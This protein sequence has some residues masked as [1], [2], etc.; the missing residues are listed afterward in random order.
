MR[1]MDRRRTPL[2]GRRLTYLAVGATRPESADWTPPPSGRLRFERTV[3]I[4]VGDACWQAASS[5]LFSWGVKTRS[6]FTVE[7]CTGDLR[8]RLGERFWLVARVGPVAVKEP[9]QVTAFVDQDDRRGFAYGTLAGH[10]VSGEEAF[11]VHRDADGAVFFSLR[12][13]TSPASGWWRVAFPAVL[14]AQRV[15]RRRYLRALP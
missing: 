13:V 8:A 6:G 12:S 7:P 14:I 3:Q 5:A 11:V 2:S 4:G 9:V 1:D 15:Y 10:P